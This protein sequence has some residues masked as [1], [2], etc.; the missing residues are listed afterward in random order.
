M[1]RA[2]NNG[3]EQR[4]LNAALKVV[5]E[6]GI[7]GTRMHLI[8][9]K[10]DM[11]QSNVHYYYKTKDQLMLALQ[12]KVIQQ[13]YEI[14]EQDIKKSEDTLEGRL[15]IFFKQKKYLITKKREYDFA[16]MDFLVQG[17]MNP[18]IH[19]C[20]VESYEQWREEIRGVLSQYCKNLDQASKEMIPY[21]IVALLQGA[22]VQALVDFKEF[23]I[24][25]YFEHCEQMILG[26]L[27][28]FGEPV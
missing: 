11:V 2:K 16:E 15:H 1:E 4:I 9:Q 18:K 25:A 26:Y 28:S 7:S 27:K 13:C 21:T 12:G 23:E 3:V 19:D 5:N 17:K 8:A 6:V 22:S 14:R 20:F 10:A 24:D